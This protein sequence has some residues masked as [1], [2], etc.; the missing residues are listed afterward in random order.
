MNHEEN[1]LVDQAITVLHKGYETTVSTF[2]CKRFAFIEQPL[3]ISWYVETFGHKFL[4][5][6]DLFI[7]SHLKDQQ[8][9]DEAVQR[10]E[11]I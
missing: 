1:M 6:G 9:D 5:C 7:F 11:N 8:C 3:L 10:D 2:T 4:H